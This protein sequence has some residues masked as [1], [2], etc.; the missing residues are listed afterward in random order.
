LS[1]VQTLALDKLTE[2][3][4]FQRHRRNS[5][6]KVLQGETPTPPSK[7]KVET[8]SLETGS[9]SGQGAQENL[10]KTEV[11]TQKGDTSL[12]NPPNDQTKT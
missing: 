3:H 5:L 7:Q 4:Y 12:T 10:E 8:Q 6:P 9:S 11:V 1:Q 2:F